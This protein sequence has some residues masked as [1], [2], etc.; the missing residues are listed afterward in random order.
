MIDGDKPGDLVPKDRNRDS[1]SGKESMFRKAEKVFENFQNRLEQIQ[2]DVYDDSAVGEDN[3]KIT[4][5][6][7]FFVIEGVNNNLLQKI[8]FYK[9]R[10]LTRKKIKAL[11]NDDADFDAGDYDV[12]AAEFDVSVEDTKD[13]IDLLKSCFDDKGH[14][15]RRSFERNIPEF[16]RYEK[17]IFEFLWHFN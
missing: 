8:E 17:K 11:V 7:D 15:L 6:D 16:I 3:I 10:A 9:S 14:F 1:V 12:I 2:D 4:D 5:G 13:I